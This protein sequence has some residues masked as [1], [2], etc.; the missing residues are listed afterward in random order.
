VVNAQ[1]TRRQKLTMPTTKVGEA[2][3]KVI[4]EVSEEEGEPL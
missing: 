3:E 2:L 4:W 1:A